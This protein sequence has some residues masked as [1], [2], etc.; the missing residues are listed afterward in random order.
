MPPVSRLWQAFASTQSAFHAMTDP[1]RLERARRRAAPLT[2]HPLV[3]VIIPTFDRVDIVCG[4]TIP[5]LLAQTYTNIEVLIVGDGCRKD[6]S[7]RLA[8]LAS[9]Q[10]AFKN[11]RWRSKYPRDPVQRWMVAGA[12][13][14][15][16]GAQ[17]IAGQVVLWMSDDDILK[18]TA[19]EELVFTLL[20][21]DV[22]IA[23]GTE[24][25]GLSPVEEAMGIIRRPPSGKVWLA[26]RHTTVLKWNRL[27]WAK[28]WNRPSD[29]DLFARLLAAGAHFSYTP[30]PVVSLIPVG[31]TGLHG[32]EAW[33]AHYRTE[34]GT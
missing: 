21:K 20:Q 19:V 5:A 3:S 14:R 33:E 16:I 6:V 24:I 23:L 8:E 15:N 34:D 18:P 12:R 7:H 10:V 31:N 2:N 27:S 17:L 4:M 30:Q 13:P 26:R 22:D 9:E 1:Y 32:S 25:G 29:Y 28:H 11:L